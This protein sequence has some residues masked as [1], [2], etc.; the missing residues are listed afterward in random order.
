M[1]GGSKGGTFGLL[2]RGGACVG[3][4]RASGRPLALGGLRPVADAQPDTLLEP[5]EV[6]LEVLAP[7]EEFVGD[8]VVVPPR[9]VG[10]GVVSAEA[11]LVYPA[12][13]ASALVL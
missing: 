3:A 13:G 5:L 6:L 11:G 4:G 2:R 8:P 9:R 12:L 7:Q 1:I 10:L